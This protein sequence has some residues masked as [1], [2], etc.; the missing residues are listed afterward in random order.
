MAAKET[1]RTPEECE[2]MSVEEIRHWLREH[3]AV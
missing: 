3:A 2:Q 1:G